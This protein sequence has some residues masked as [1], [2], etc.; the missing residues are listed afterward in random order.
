M[1]NPLRYAGETFY[2]SGYNVDAQGVETS[3]LQVV[4]NTGWMIPYVSCM[5]AATGMLAH[6]FFFCCDSCSGIQEK[7]NGEAQARTK[8]CDRSDPSRKPRTTVW[9]SHGVACTGSRGLAWVCCGL[10][11]KQ[12]LRR[13]LATECKLDEFGELPVMYEGRVKPFDTLARNSPR[14]LSNRETLCRCRRTT[15]SRDSLVAGRDRPAHRSG[16]DTGVPH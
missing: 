2:Q 6:F 8:S 10:A 7:A 12:C 13:Q 3:T 16:T 14:I 4:R 1:N 15:K 11:R 5:I 9:T